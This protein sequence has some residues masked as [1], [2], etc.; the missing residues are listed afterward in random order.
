MKYST[1]LERL[2]NLINVTPS[3]SEIAKITDLKEKNVYA[4]RSQDREFSEEEIA[5]I[6][7]YYNVTLMS[8]PSFDDCVD[9]EYIHLSPSCGRGSFLFEEPEITPIRLGKKMLEEVLRVSDTNNLKVFRASGDSMSSTIDDGNLL[10]VDIGRTDFNNGGIFLIQKNNEWYIKRLNLKLS[11]ELEVIS[12]NPKYEK[13]VFKPNDMIE[14]FVR[15]RVIKN[16]SKG[17]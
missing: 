16:L 14:I 13:E 6:E 5:K 2:Q 12:D 11:G 9:V 3:V 7:R 17:I 1:V 8:A 4:R 10:L 15:G